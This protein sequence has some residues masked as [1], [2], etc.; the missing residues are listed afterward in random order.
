MP[1]GEVRG[2]T[3]WGQKP[4][5]EL[6]GLGFGQRNVGGGCFRVEGTQLG[7][8]TLGLVWWGCDP[9]TREMGELVFGAKSQIQAPAAWI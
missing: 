4:K 8:G 1:L 3:C 5:T 7:W 2:G 9:E 6:L